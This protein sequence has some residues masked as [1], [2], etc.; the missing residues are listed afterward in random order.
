LNLGWSR[1]PNS[2]I[3]L[4]CI[5]QHTRNSV[6]TTLGNCSCTR[7]PKKQVVLRALCPVEFDNDSNTCL[8]FRTFFD[9]C[10]LC[11]LYVCSQAGLQLS[12][13]A[14]QL[15]YLLSSRLFSATARQTHM[16]HIHCFKIDFSAL[17]V[18][19]T[20]FHDLTRYLN[21]FWFIVGSIITGHI[22]V[23]WLQNTNH[24]FPVRCNTFRCS[25]S[26]FQCRQM[27]SQESDGAKLISS[28]HFNGAQNGRTLLYPCN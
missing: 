20:R 9:T 7:A 16:A 23:R 4:T 3:Q 17:F 2:I 6:S 28:K 12:T 24:E 5:V 14:S 26:S 15:M 25:V 8:I 13:D 27:T 1:L 18:M 19:Y 21:I 11:S 10:V 22:R